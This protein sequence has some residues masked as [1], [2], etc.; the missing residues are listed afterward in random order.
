MNAAAIRPKPWVVLSCS[1]ICWQLGRGK[2]PINSQVNTTV[3]ELLKAAREQQFSKVRGECWKVYFFPFFSSS[4]RSFPP[5]KDILSFLPLS[6]SFLIF[7]S[8]FFLLLLLCSVCAKSKWYVNT[9]WKKGG[10]TTLRR[11]KKL[12]W[13]SNKI[14]E[15]VM[16][17][18]LFSC[19]CSPLLFF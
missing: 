5:F 18:S 19:C 6:L 1:H 10:R 13:S 4:T 2:V 12:L 14:G 8:S 9:V 3:K 7:R 17:L 15:N 11:R 16:W